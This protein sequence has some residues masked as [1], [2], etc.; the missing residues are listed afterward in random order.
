MKWFESWFDTEFYH[1]LYNNRNFTEAEEF[2]GRITNRLQLQAGDRVADICCGKGR[3]SQS[4]AQLGFEVWGMDLSKNSIEFARSLGVVGAEFEV[5]D[6]R[7]PFNHYN[8]SAVFNLFTSFGYFETKEEDECALQNMANATLPN[9]YVVQD[10]LNAASVIDQMPQ[11]Y[12]EERGDIHFEIEKLVEGKKI[13]K[14]INV[15][16]VGSSALLGEFQEE[17]QI[18]TAEELFALHSQAGL[19]VVEVLG[20]YHLNAYESKSSPRIIVVSK[21]SGKSS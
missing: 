21:K 3:H 6:I 12:V 17:V 4:M 2:I 5:H 19:E 18:Y 8:F 1:L 7:K 14:R 11:K 13:L 20:D 15:K 9:G 10:Y 16:Q